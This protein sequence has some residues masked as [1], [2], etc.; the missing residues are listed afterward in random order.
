VDG[1]KPGSEWRGVVHGQRLSDGQRL[2]VCPSR[3]VQIGV[4]GAGPDGS[5][6]TAINTPRER[7]ID[8]TRATESSGA[9]SRQ[10]MSA[11]AA[12]AGAGPVLLKASGLGTT[13]AFA[14]GASVTVWE[15]NETTVAALDGPGAGEAGTTGIPHGLAT[16]TPMNPTI[17]TRTSP[18]VLR[19]LTAPVTRW[20]SGVVGLSIVGDTSV[21]QCS[22]RVLGRMTRVRLCA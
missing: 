15:G 13:G 22:F 5:P 4:V 14:R 16:A 20:L 8:R 10:R 12:M 11:D 9:S 21:G 1:V 6:P 3:D 7:S 18:I 17:S 19:P 2:P